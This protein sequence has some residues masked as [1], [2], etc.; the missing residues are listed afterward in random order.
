MKFSGLLI[1]AALVASTL[2]TSSWA[3]DKTLSLLAQA[4]NL[5]SY[6]GRP[7]K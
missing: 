4:L 5:L 7:L 6:L 2:S 3:Q 1:G